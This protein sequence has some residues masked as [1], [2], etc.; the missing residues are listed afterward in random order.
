M[1]GVADSAERGAGLERLQAH[2]QQGTARVAKR[3][4]YQN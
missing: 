3:S 2:R 1:Q 4:D